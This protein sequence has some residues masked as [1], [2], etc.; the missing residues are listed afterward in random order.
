MTAIWWIKLL[1]PKAGPNTVI[2]PALLFSL[3]YYLEHAQII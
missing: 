2:G 1:E 3:Q